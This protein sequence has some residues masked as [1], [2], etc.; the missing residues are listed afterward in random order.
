M[1]DAVFAEGLL[2][3]GGEFARRLQDERARHARPGASL[4]E[5]RQHRQREGG[6][7]AGAGLGDAQN[8]A[9]LQRV[10]NGLRLD[11]RRR[12]VAGRFDGVEHFLAQAEFVE[13]HGFS[14]ARMIRIR[15]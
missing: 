8:V 13:F 12:V 15:D 6:G 3:L 7:L 1:V 4:F 9:A 10:G 14:L 2:D 5:H 11:W